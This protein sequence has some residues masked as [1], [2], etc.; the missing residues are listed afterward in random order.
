MANKEDFEQDL[1]S[2]IC[3]F[4]PDEN[5]GFRMPEDAIANI[6]LEFNVRMQCK[7]YDK[8]SSVETLLEEINRKL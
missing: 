4:E 2:V 8:L 6:L 7:L 5:G 1:D 3:S